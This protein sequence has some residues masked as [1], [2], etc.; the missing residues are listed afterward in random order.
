MSL[1]WVPLY[2]VSWHLW[3]GFRNKRRNKI[4]FSLEFFF[5]PFQTNP[6]NKEN[7]Q[8]L[9]PWASTIK[10]LTAVINV[11]VGN[12]KGGISMYCRPPV[13]FGLV[14]FANKNKNC[15]LS[16]SWFQTSQTGGQRYSDTPPLVFPGCSAGKLVH[17]S[18]PA[19][20]LIFV[21]TVRSAPLQWYPQR[22]STLVGSDLPHRYK[23]SIR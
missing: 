17:S 15:Q 19:Y 18:L 10:P 1:G 3:K 6:F 23:A 12:T 21:S 16:C 8:K 13:W 4:C 11:A 9:W 14:C 20:S 5:L 2:R 22:G 7:I